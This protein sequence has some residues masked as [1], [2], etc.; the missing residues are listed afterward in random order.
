MFYWEPFGPWHVSHLT[1]TT[2]LK[3]V[4]D[5]AVATQ[6]DSVPCS[7]TNTAQDWPKAH[8]K[9]LPIPQIL[10]QCSTSWTCLNKS[11]PWRPHCGS[12]LSLTQGKDTRPA[13]HQGV[14]GGYFQSCGWRA[15]A[16][17]IGLVLACLTDAQ[18]DQDVGNLEARSTPRALCHS[19]VIF[20]QAGAH[21]SAGETTAI[22]ECCCH[23]GHGVVCSGVWMGGASI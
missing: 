13:W 15:G 4:A 2:H 5:M 6:Q 8:D 17:W 19:Q 23:G 10:I 21:C 18:L 11:Y 1:R 9:E 22:R 14:G 7:L 16:P 20:E 3:A 12:N